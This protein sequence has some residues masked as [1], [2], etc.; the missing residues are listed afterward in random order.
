MTYLLTF[1]LGALVGAVLGALA[2]YRAHLRWAD[3][4]HYRRVRLEVTR[5][6]ELATRADHDHRTAQ[7]WA[8]ALAALQAVHDEVVGDLLDK[9]AARDRQLERRRARRVGRY[10][11]S[12]WT[13]GQARARA[14]AS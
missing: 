9:V 1:V 6:H 4:H 12:V 14:V 13:Y 3:E 8:R 10:S 2:V 5:V 7:R 11:P